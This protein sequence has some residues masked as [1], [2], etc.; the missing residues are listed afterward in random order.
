MKR[1]NHLS[2]NLKTYQR[3]RGKTLSEFSREI[4]IAKSTLQSV[5]VDGNTTVD[6]LI[7]IANALG[8]TLGELVFGNIQRVEI[9]AVRKVLSEVEWYVQIPGDKQEKMVYHLSEL[10]KLIEEAK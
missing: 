2:D 9:D 4:G 10:M 7:R 6:T 3:V 5:M 8:V 1:D